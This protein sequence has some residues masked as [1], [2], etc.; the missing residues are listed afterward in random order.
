M[1]TIT[2]ETVKVI[3]QAGAVGISVLLI[4]VIYKLVTN[5]G[6]HLID[7]VDRNTD[8]WKENAQSNIETAKALANLTTTLDLTHKKKK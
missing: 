8:A 7:V 4:M 5:H 2:S 6:K 3:V 1:E